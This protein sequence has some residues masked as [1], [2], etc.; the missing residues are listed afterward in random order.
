MGRVQTVKKNQFIFFHLISFFWSWGNIMQ[1]N[2]MGKPEK[3]EIA[4]KA[5]ERRYVK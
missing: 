3:E 4:T 1:Q 5:W 2:S